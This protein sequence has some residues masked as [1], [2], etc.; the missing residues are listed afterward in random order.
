MKKDYLQPLM[1]IVIIESTELIC[2]SKD[3]TSDVGIDYGG[4]D[5]DGEKT[6]DS[7][8]HRTVWDDEEVLELED[9][10]F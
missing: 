1:T 7:R 2:A 3:I 8:R 6:V 10:D 5:E 4:I 9:E